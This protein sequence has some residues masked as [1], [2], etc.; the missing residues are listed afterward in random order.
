MYNNAL[1]TNTI[2]H[3]WKRATIIPIPKPNKDHNIG[4]NYRPIS[5]LSPIAKALEKTPLAYI[6]ENIPAISHQHGFKHK[7]STDTALHNIC[8]Q[9]TSGFNNPRSPQ[10]TVAVTLDMTKGF[11][12]VNILTLT[13]IPNINIKFITNY[14]K[15][16]QAWTQYNSTLSKLKRINTGVPQGRV[17]SPTLFN[18]YTSDIP[19]PPKDIQIT[20][21]ADD[22]TTTA[23]H[24]KH[25]KA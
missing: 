18:I 22:I 11:D 23:S 19:L 10:R 3:L 5:L 21:Y 2:P 12:T 9:I 16:R 24:T 15:G 4:T 6:T 20:T 8:H 1:N 14:I 13:N 17:L 7:Q 25:R